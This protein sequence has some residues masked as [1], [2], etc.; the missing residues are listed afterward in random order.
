M[1]TKKENGDPLC[2]LF[3]FLMIWY[4]WISITTFLGLVID[5]VII[6][7][8]SVF[9]FLA[10]GCVV[11]LPI[12]YNF[13]LSTSPIVLRALSD[14]AVMALTSI[15]EIGGIGAVGFFLF[16]CG[17]LTTSHCKSNIPYLCPSDKKKEQ[18]NGSIR[19][20]LDT[21][22]QGVTFLTPEVNKTTLNVILGTKTN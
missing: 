10:N 9:N 17:C 21:G 8:I 15:Y 22:G 16:A 19:A 7:V 5:S 4:F 14:S 11:S 6:V 2:G 13:T 3:A 20:D 18:S 1:G 12:I